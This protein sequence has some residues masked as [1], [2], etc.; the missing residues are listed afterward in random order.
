M[1]LRFTLVFK[2]L[3]NGV[4][5]AY[6]DLEALLTNSEE[7]LGKMFKALPPFIQHWITKLPAKYTH[8]LGP[9]ILAAAAEKPGAKADMFTKGADVASKAGIKLKVPNLK[10][11]VS[12]QG[13][14]LGMFRT[15]INSLRTRFP[16]LGS[17]NVIWSLAITIL[18]LV[19]WYCHKRGKEVRLE[20]ERA[21]T[22]AEIA[23]IKAQVESEPPAEWHGPM[24]TTAPE[25][26]SIEEVRASLAPATSV[27][28]ARASMEYAEGGSL[29]KALK[30]EEQQHK[31]QG[32]KKGKSA[33]PGEP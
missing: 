27:V 24:T 28:P 18:L 7:Q 26:A 31:K 4:P 3:V 10:D 29:A 25:G 17:L 21:V 20:K 14:L 13:P 23:A 16:A 30:E 33:Q 12:K 8:L 5:T 15:I 2:D 19:C 22:E 1:L 6:H 9:E 11:L 32:E